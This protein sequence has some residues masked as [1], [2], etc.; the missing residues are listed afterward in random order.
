MTPPPEFSAASLP[1]RWRRRRG[2]NA[3]S[4]PAGSANRAYLFAGASF[5]CVRPGRR[6]DGHR[7]AGGDRIGR[8]PRHRRRRRATA[9]SSSRAD[10][11][12]LSGSRAAMR[13][14]WKAP[15]TRG[16]STRDTDAHDSMDAN[17]DGHHGHRRRRRHHRSGGGPFVFR[18]LRGFSWSNRGGEYVL[19]S[20][21]ING[22][23]RADAARQ[24][25]SNLA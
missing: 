7:S 10:A 25:Q 20:L 17:A 21:T 23:D 18:H 12:I 9:S 5:G 1:R 4:G 24:G 19:H 14:C 6:S 11:S 22:A 13:W 15:S 3:G 16:C 8:L 2:R